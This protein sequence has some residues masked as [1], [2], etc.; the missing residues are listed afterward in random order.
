[1][2]QNTKDSLSSE[3]AE[4]LYRHQSSLWKKIFDV[5]LPY[6]LNL[7]H[8]NPGLTLD[9]GCG[10]GRNLRNLGKNAVGVDPN[11]ECVNLARRAGFTAF[12]PDE[13]PLMSFDTLLFAHVLEH[14]ES[15]ELLIKTYLPRL[16]EGGQLILITPQELGF[17]RDPSHIK[18]LGFRDLE[19]IISGLGLKLDRSYSFPFPRIFGQYFCYNEFVVVARK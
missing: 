4:Q 14:V 16:R 3:Y 6:R 9:V 11:V 13:L 7:Q 17:N 18:F 2:A 5:Q 8:L 15:P 19:A 12:L 10:V 1:M